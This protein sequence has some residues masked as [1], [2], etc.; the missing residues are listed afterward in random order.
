MNV[1][2][3]LSLNFKDNIIR[4]I[5]MAYYM[6]RGQRHKS[7]ISITLDD[8]VLAFFSGKGRSGRINYVLTQYLLWNLGHNTDIGFDETTPLNRVTSARSACQ[9][10]FGDDSIEVQLMDMIRER[11]K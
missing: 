6:S 10:V 1:Y 9:E 11:M 7:A 2:V 8:K 3:A 4:K 5:R